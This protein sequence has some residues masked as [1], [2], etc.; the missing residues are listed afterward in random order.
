MITNLQK[1]EK[2][3]KIPAIDYAEAQCF[4]I[5]ISSNP[6][7]QTKIRVEE[8]P[9]SDAGKKLLC[10]RTLE[11]TNIIAF[12]YTDP[13]I[14]LENYFKLYHSLQLTP[15]LK[16]NRIFCSV[17]TISSSKLMC[18]SESIYARLKQLHLIGQFSKNE[19]Q[20]LYLPLLFEGH[21]QFIDNFHWFAYNSAIKNKFLYIAKLCAQMIKYTQLY[22]K[23]IEQFG[24]FPEIIILNQNQGTPK[25]IENIFGSKT[26]STSRITIVH[27]NTHNSRDTKHRL[28]MKH[29]A[30]QT[31]KNMKED[32]LNTLKQNCV[33]F[34]SLSYFDN[35]LPNTIQAYLIFENMLNQVLNVKRFYGLHKDNPFFQKAFDHQLQITNVF[36]KFVELLIPYAKNVTRVFNIELEQDVDIISFRSISKVIPDTFR[37]EFET[38][39][40]FTSQNR[41]EENPIIPPAILLESLIQNYTEASNHHTPISE[42]PQSLSLEEKQAIELLKAENEK[43][44]KEKKEKAENIAQQS[45]LVREQKKQDKGKTEAENKKLKAQKIVNQHK[46]ETQ[47]KELKEQNERSKLLSKI[48]DLPTSEFVQKEII[49]KLKGKLLNYFQIL[50][51]LVPNDNV[52]NHQQIHDLTNHIKIILSKHNI[53]C[54]NDL[55]SEVKARTHVRH[56]SDTGNLMP[57]NYV[58]ILRTC[59]ILFGIFPT[60]WEPKTV[61]DFDAM[62]KYEQRQL[63]ALLF[64]AKVKFV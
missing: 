39:K 53:E 1:K 13:K 48:H 15:F 37:E 17:G 64:D 16:D 59:F 8:N 30:L 21:F 35:L 19:I 57:T 62:L 60:N 7:D 56:D 47:E 32:I 26:G 40:Q 20:K 52:I 29:T 49:E 10:N 3:I 58:D 42:S 25:N 63:D 34:A 50:F 14:L 33:V 45:H 54:A 46:Q 22:C 41:V 36:I 43:L 27:N 23:R 12:E 44:S 38:F 61:E 18:F 11:S 24:D 6:T 51:G 9:S 31:L 4:Q 28:Q 2:T 5:N 55:L